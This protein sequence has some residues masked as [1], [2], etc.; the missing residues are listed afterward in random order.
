MLPYGDIL[1]GI[2]LKDGRRQPSCLLLSA[3]MVAAVML[4]SCL[5]HEI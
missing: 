2:L 1:G 3:N 5:Q 4:P